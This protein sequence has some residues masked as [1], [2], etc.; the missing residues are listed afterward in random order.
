[1]RAAK[2]LVSTEGMRWSGEKRQGHM[3]ALHT[4][5]YPVRPLPCALDS[6]FFIIILIFMLKRPILQK[7]IYIY[8]FFNQKFYLILL[9][10]LCRCF[11]FLALF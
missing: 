6:I 7:Y 10:E 5:D 4:R 1:V 8:F 9:F 11:L 2:Y 3:A